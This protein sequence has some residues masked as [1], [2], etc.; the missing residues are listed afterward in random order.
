MRDTTQVINGICK[1][2]KNLSAIS[3]ALLLPHYALGYAAKGHHIVAYICEENLT[4]RSREVVRE[5]LPNSTLHEVSTWADEE[6]ARTRANGTWHYVDFEITTGK[7]APENLQHS[8]ILEA[9]SSN[10]IAL[11]AS[12]RTET[13]Q[14]ALKY[15]VHFFGD[16]HQPLHCANNHD[17]GGNKTYVMYEGHE[18]RLHHIWDDE[19]VN[20]MLEHRYN[21]MSLEQAAKAISQK[22]ISHFDEIVSGTVHTW[23]KESFEIAKKYVY[24]LAE[25][26]SGTQAH[27]LTQEYLDRSEEI[28]EQQFA[29]AGFRLAHYLNSLLDPDY[30]ASRSKGNIVQR[31]QEVHRSRTPAGTRREPAEVVH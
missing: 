22:H 21:G 20:R 24:D 15:L 10:T 30:L 27:R 28:L 4:T 31:E 16:L 9:I 13:R 14:E 3:L 8:T 23:A 1:I 5:L 2:L 7:I 17:N 6:R 18:E 12:P 26:T 25:P 19:L 11:K 29:K